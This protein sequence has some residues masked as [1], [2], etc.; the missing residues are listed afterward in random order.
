[1][2]QQTLSGELL[3]GRIAALLGSPARLA[4]MSVAARRLARPDAA[5]VI[6]DKAI[7]LATARR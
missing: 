3:A 2:E 7:A 1:V 5:R 4:E 6:A